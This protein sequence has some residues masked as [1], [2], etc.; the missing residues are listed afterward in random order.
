MKTA[1]KFSAWRTD[2]RR[3]LRVG[4]ISF[5]ATLLGTL[6]VRAGVN[7]NGDTTP[8][9]T[10]EETPPPN[11]IT[12]LVGG[13]FTN[14]DE[15]QFQRRHWQTDGAFG[16]IEDFHYEQDVGKKGSFKLDG[17]A[18]F[19]NDDYEGRFELS[20]T[21]VGYI[22]AGYRQYRTWY[23][24][25]GGY[26]SGDNLFLQL[27]DNDLAIDRGDAWV[28]LGLRMPNL[29]EITFRYDHQFRNGQKDSTE[30]GDT[31]LTNL[32]TNAT[33]NI[34][35]TFLDIDEKRDTFALDIKQTISNTDLGLGLRYD[36]T[37][38]NDS[39]NIRRRP[40]RTGRSFPDRARANQLRSL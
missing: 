34:V 25:N 13:V 31:N 27:Y 28:E 6:P 7:A 8:T 5:C 1:R 38:N 37:D 11:W 12:L 2:S 26:F 9:P 3:W 10:P 35:P 22:R 20:Q 40:L 32:T 30:W 14:G 17:H 21:D 33:R 15:A 29:P 18:I 36:T 24:G 16:G 4:A 23:D 19:G 39:R